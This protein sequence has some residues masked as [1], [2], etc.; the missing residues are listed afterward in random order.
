MG[1]PGCEAPQTRAAA[2][3][4]YDEEL[5]LRKKDL[6]QCEEID[7]AKRFKEKLAAFRAI[8]GHSRQGWPHIPVTTKDL[9]PTQDELKAVNE[10]VA[11][12]GTHALKNMPGVDVTELR[13]FPAQVRATLGN[14]CKHFVEPDSIEDLMQLEFFY[15]EGGVLVP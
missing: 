2:P 10:A 14:H 15:G 11:R 7:A 1:S 12:R 9:E 5:Q 13:S 3:P 8:R 6:E 4:D